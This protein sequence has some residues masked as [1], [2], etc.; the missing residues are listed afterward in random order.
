MKELR[1]GPGFARQQGAH[2]PQNR[3]TRV[4]P[5]WEPQLTLP[6]ICRQ[7]LERAQA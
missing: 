4:S 1:L 5:F 6:I 2:P 7:T 3:L